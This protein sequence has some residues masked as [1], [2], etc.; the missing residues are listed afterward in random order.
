M[1]TGSRLKFAQLKVWSAHMPHARRPR[2]LR[3]ERP[4]NVARSRV[5]K[6]RGSAHAPAS[7][8]ARILDVH[9]KLTLLAC[10]PLAPTPLEL[11]TADA[12]AWGAAVQRVS[13]RS[14]E[15]GK[16]HVLPRAHVPARKQ[17]A[18]NAHLKLARLDRT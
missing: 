13:C 3:G 7:L 14:V 9:L 11:K 18:S 2:H 16:V 12:P 10:L 17:C 15:S 8:H 6:C 4:Y 5:G 1:L